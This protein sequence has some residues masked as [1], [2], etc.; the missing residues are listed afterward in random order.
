MDAADTDIS[1]SFNSSEKLG[2]VADWVSATVVSGFFSSLDRFSCVN[3]STT[4]PDDD[5]LPTRPRPSAHLLLKIVSH[6]L[7]I[8]M[9]KG[10]Q[11]DKKCKN[12]MEYA[13]FGLEGKLLSLSYFWILDC[14]PSSSFYPIFLFRLLIN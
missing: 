8:R 7:K 1:R 9:Q 10:K 4:D 13:N 14:F 11:G 2:E 6:S 12:E 5:D 3:L